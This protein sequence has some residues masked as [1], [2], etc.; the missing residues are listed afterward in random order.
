M[1]SATPRPHLQP[2]TSAPVT[3]PQWRGDAAARARADDAR[4]TSPLA[5]LLMAAYRF[6]PLRKLVFSLAE[7]LEGGPILSRTPRAL[8]AK[9][10]GVEIGAYSYGPILR[11]PLLPAGS[12]VG[13]YCS[14]GSGLIVRRR[15]H[16]LA[17]P[18]LHPFFYNS[19]LGLLDS[20]T[21]QGNEEN[22]LE[23][24]H[25]VWI[26]DRVTILSGCKRVGNGAVLAAGAVVTGDVPDYAIMGGVPA[27]MIRK[28]FDEPTIARLE[29]SRW[30][31][32][33]IA[34][35]IDD[36]DLP[37]PFEDLPKP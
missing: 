10:H 27:K 17:R 2:A 32:R 9:F 3:R 22:P 11:P 29:E 7:R 35:L 13:R 6:R 26:G 4:A 8:M 36:P 33:D 34:D 12:R 25:D 19:W 30:W 5:G 21:I 20:D 15:D 16:P 1:S 28:R 24:G 18:Y 14:V 23:I 31:E 37:D